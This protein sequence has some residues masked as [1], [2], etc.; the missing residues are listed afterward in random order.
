MRLRTCVLTDGG[1]I[2]GGRMAVT[3][4]VITALLPRRHDV[5]NTLRLSQGG[6]GW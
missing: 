1:E 6:A 4:V 5:L 3:S 2:M